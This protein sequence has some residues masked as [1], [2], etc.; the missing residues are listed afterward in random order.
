MDVSRLAV[1]RVDLRFGG[2][3]LHFLQLGFKLIGKL[4][5]AALRGNS[6]K[7]IK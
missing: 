3:R 4:A 7:L 1:R 2:I 5:Y 6:D